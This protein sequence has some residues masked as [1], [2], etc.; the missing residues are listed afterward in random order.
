[1]RYL[2]SVTSAVLVLALGC[3]PQPA[4]P[5]PELVIDLEAERSSLMAADLAWSQAYST[6]EEP[7][8]V[9]AG[10]VVDDSYLLPPGAPMVRGKVNIREFIAGL[11]A[12]PEFSVSWSP[13]A[14]TVSA[15]GDMGYT[16]GGYQMTMAPEGAPTQIDGKYL[17]VWKKQADGSWMVSADMFNAN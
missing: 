14:A 12:S 3:A 5:P 15:D 7:A 16:V 2:L 6:S 13:T 11:E 4:A 9:F 8:D 10:N 1:M 17:T